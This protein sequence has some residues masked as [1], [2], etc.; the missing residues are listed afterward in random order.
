[1][2][3]RLKVQEAYL[4]DAGC[5]LIASRLCVVSTSSRKN[6]FSLSMRRSAPPAALPSGGRGVRLGGL[7]GLG[8]S[9]PPPRKKLSLT[10][11][12]YGLEITPL[13]SLTHPLQ[14]P[15]TITVMFLVHQ[16]DAATPYN[17]GLV[18]RE[19][20]PEPAGI[21]PVAQTTADHWC[22]HRVERIE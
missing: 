6:C 4:G 13:T 8:A 18:L 10:Y 16:H 12:I 22:G 19:P 5:S 3:P 17:P 14:A 1:M 15:L 2:N 21:N 11:S 7:G 20:V 9:V